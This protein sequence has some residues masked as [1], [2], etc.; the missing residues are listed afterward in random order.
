MTNRITN[1]PALFSAGQDPALIGQRKWRM[2][3]RQE[4]LTPFVPI[5]W[6]PGGHLQTLAS[7]YW[8]RQPF[9]LPSETEPV[10]V[11]PADGSR[12]LCHTHWQ[13][14]PVRSGR[15]TLLLLHGLEG[16][17][18]SRYMHRIASRAW[19]LG[20]NV[21]RMNMRNCGGT[22]AWTPTLYHSGFSGDVEAVL[23]HF[24]SRYALK[25][26]AMAGYSMGGNL[27]LKLAGELGTG[28]PEW[29]AA[30]VAVSPAA[31]LAPSADALHE[32][33]NRLYEW[34][35]LRNL[36]RR[37]ERKASLFPEIYANAGIGPIRSIREFD[38][39]ITARFHGFNGADEYYSRSAGARVVPHV[40]IPTLVIHAL[41]DP[42]IRLTGTTRNAMLQNPSIMLVESKHGGHCAFL[43]KKSAAD[44]TSLS[45][46]LAIGRHWAEATL[47]RFLMATVGHDAR[48]LNDQSGGNT[49][50]S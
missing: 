21:I 22:E 38:H 10:V 35:F 26:V 8:R 18:D 49:H 17:S 30:A 3:P 2:A 46:G 15:L 20:C 45:P 1:Q 25:R 27:V 29:L 34:N 12:V 36:M 44:G 16:S 6:L 14:E 37:F 41:D 4:W 9:N 48:P 40:A 13:P 28:A 33:S 42:F 50:G 19:S 7:N 5:P 31:D 23:R 47:V 11:D 39:R 24:V 32:P 43:A